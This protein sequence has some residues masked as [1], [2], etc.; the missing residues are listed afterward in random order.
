MSGEPTL[1]SLFAGCG[2]SSLGYRRAGFRELLAVDWDGNAVGTFKLNFPH[3]PVWQRDIR[4][5][6]GKEVLEFCSLRKGELDLLDGS[7]PCQGYSTAGKRQVID[8]RNDLFLENIRLIG[9]LEP[10]VFLVENVPGMIRGI[11]KGLFK[12]YMELLRELPYKVKCKLMNTKWY[13]VPQSRQRLIWLGI[14][15]DLGKDPCYPEPCR[16]VITLKKALR[17]ISSEKAKR[18]GKKTRVYLTWHL[19]KRGDSLARVT[20]KGHDFNR[21]RLCWNKPC[22]TVPKY[23][24]SMLHPDE[25]RY[26]SV[27]EIK[28]VFSYPDDFQFA[29]DRGKG[30]SALRAIEQMGNSVPPKFMEIVARHIKDEILSV[31]GNN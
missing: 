19:V 21:R 6:R 12:Q 8:S 11:M 30:D 20:A 7:P 27:S 23:P 29:P 22:V 4:K 14:R 13:R 31:A 9:E 15:T 28:R 1:V 25:P 17:D 26:L 2:G 16:D 18:P 24:Y 5:V 10:R 3:V